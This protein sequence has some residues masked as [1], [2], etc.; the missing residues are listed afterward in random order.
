MNF[1][2]LERT[3]ESIQEAKREIIL[4][5]ATNRNRKDLDDAFQGLVTAERS[6]ERLLLV[7]EKLPS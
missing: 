2:K 4:I 7:P 6:I 5:E 1:D 3:L